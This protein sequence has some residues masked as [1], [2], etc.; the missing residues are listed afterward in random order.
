M[1]AELVI[2]GITK[3]PF[4]PTGIPL[5]AG[6]DLFTGS[7]F[8]RQS[9]HR[10]TAKIEANCNRHRFTPSKKTGMEKQ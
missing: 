4:L 1:M 6:G 5:Y 8:H 2:R 9:S 10:I 7:A 3:L